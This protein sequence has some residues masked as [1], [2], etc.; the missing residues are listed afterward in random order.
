MLGEKGQLLL[1]TRD[2][3]KLWYSCS[4]SILWR[5]RRMADVRSCEARCT[6]MRL[7]YRLVHLFL[8]LS[9]GL[10]LS[11]SHETDDSYFLSM[12]PAPSSS[13]VHRCYQFDTLLHPPF[14][15][16]NVIYY[17][18]ENNNISMFLIKP[19]TISSHFSIISFYNVQLIFAISSS[20][21]IVFS[22]L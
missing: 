6:A 19:N 17:L 8:S 14:T 4:R 9:L 7:L 18:Q 21:A 20:M 16:T 11:F 2:E 22:K 5:W 12:P 13:R 10:F 3:T 15:L 1:D